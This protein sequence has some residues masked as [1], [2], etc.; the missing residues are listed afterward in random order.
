[1][2]ADSSG[3]EE[4][5][6]ID[7]VAAEWVVKHDLGL[8]A[9]EQDDFFQWLGEDPSHSDAFARQQNTWKEF[10]L[11]SQWMPEHSGEPNPDLLAKGDAKN[12]WSRWRN[13]QSYVAYAA[14]LALVLT[15]WGIQG[16]F[17]EGSV[18]ETVQSLSAGDYAY[19]VLSDGSELDM[20]SGSKVSIEYSESVR[21]VQLL[22]G[23]VHFTVAKNPDRPFVVRAGGKD[24]RAV[25]TA[26]NVLLDTASVDVLVTEGK[27]RVNSSRTSD[28]SGDGV[29]SVINGLDMV[30]GQRS[31]LPLGLN[32]WDVDLAE[33]NSE[34]IKEILSWKHEL[35]DFDSVPLGQVVE[36][37]NRRNKL[38]MV[39][40]DDSLRGIPIVASFRSNNVEGFARLLELTS[41]V[42]VVRVNEFEMS[43]LRSD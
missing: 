22:A 35:F 15:F 19:H 6:S 34:G 38:K 21:L 13:W 20:N 10:D 9:E 3:G 1:M 29:E 30:M 39:V 18:E 41:N 32:K 16:D 26:F 24:V 40:V 12:R 43:L 14:I 5:N 28:V 42:T 2:N 25:G 23:E 27:V 31:V 36:A 7:A 37:F 11:L 8:S 33:V 4:N 17:N